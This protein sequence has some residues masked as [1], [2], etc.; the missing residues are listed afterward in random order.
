MTTFH[1][2]S[3]FPAAFFP[4]LQN[5][6]TE[7]KVDFN[8]SCCTHENLCLRSN[9]VRKFDFTRPPS[10]LV[11]EYLFVKKKKRRVFVFLSL[12]S[13]EERL[14]AQFDR[15]IFSAKKNRTFHLV[16]GTRKLLREFR[17]L[18]VRIAS[19]KNIC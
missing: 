8:Y 10:I 5:P 11:S 18:I 6:F 4:L 19:Y 1:L 13:N 7:K 16:C 2:A 15:G 17:I 14:R 12:H 3:R 9:F